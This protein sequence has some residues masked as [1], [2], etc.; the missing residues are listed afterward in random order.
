MSDLSKEL[1]KELLALYCSIR[2]TIEKRLGEFEKIWKDALDEDI[3]PELAFCL[4]TP[5]SKANLCWEAIEKLV[6]KNSY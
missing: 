2:P 6:K 3:F 1:L 5:Q 4:L